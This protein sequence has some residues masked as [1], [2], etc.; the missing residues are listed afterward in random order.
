[1]LKVKLDQNWRQC[2]KRLGLLGEFLLTF[3][4]CLLG[5]MLKMMPTCV[6]NK[7]VVIGGDAHI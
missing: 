1:M 3:A 2:A 4:F 7:L 6:Q 5:A